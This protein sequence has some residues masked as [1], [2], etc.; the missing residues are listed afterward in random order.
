MKQI[1]YLDLNFKNLFASLA[2]KWTED[3]NIRGGLDNNYQNTYIFSQDLLLYLEELLKLH[4]PKRPLLNVCFLHQGL[5]C[6]H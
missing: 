5:C 4:G 6:L 3:K 1:C 2:R